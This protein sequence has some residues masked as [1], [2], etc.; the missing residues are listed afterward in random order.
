MS[1]NTA[2]TV[3]P[4][5]AADEPAW[6]ELWTAYLAFYESSVPEPV[7]ASTFARLLGDDPR[8]FNALVAELDGRLVGLTHYLF[9]RHAWKI[10]E[11]CYLQD[12][13]AVPDVR[14]QG[15]G[16]ALIQGVYDKADAHGAATVYWLTQDFN[17]TAR[18]LY[19]R[20]GTLTPFIKYQRT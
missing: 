7:Y 3:R 15:I 19:D 5:A 18:Q 20:I 14:G 1:P 9:H 12:L 13:Y 6:R 11:V 8:D 4:L 17:T 10:E 16:R 2:L